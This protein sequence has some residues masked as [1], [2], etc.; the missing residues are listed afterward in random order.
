MWWSISRDK[1]DSLMVLGFLIGLLAFDIGGFCLLSYESTVVGSETGKISGIT[2]IMMNEPRKYTYF[3]SKVSKP[4][5]L[6]MGDLPDILYDAPKESGMWI[7]YICQ[8]R[9]DGRVDSCRYVIHLHSIK[10]LEGGGWDHGKFGQ[11]Q[12]IPLE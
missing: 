2:R 11:G 3:L 10:E 8:K 7:D 9:R 6:Q 12:T 4:Q 1:K 5:V